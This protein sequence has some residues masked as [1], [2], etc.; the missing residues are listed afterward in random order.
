MKNQHYL[1]LSIF[2]IIFTFLKPKI[3][4]SLVFMEENTFEVPLWFYLITVTIASSV[5]FV[6]ISQIILNI[7]LGHQVMSAVIRKG[8]KNE[9]L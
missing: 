5:Y 3:I 2:F 8:G 7:P 4:P 6:S 9:R 1:F